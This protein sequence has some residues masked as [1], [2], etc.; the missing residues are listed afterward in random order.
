MQRGVPAGLVPRRQALS[1]A[2]WTI[3]TLENMP[4]QVGGPGAGKS[5]PA[6]AE[7]ASQGLAGTSTCQ[8]FEM[9]Q[10]PEFCDGRLPNTPR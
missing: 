9:P 3:L 7:P 2:A 8:A 5:L 6:P 10:G 4:R 1:P